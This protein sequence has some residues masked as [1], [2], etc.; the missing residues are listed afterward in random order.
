M[1]VTTWM[2]WEGGVDLV[3]ATRPDLTQPNV[4][5]HIARIVHTPAGSAPSGMVLYQ[6]D[7]GG[8]PQAIGFLSHD[9]GVGAFFGPNIF[10]GTPFESAP[11]LTAKVEV[12]TTD[13]PDAVGARV[14]LLDGI[15][16]ETRLS[17]LGELYTIHRPAEALPFIQ[18]GVEAKAASATLSVNG[19]SVPLYLPPV[20]IS[21][22]PPAVWAPCGVYAR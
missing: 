9:P 16:F 19:E 22:G 10:A 14:T 15:T 6:P 12:F 8:P 1:S 2:S 21:G 17:G 20:G 18:Q 7:P 5:V 3:A 11:V 4:I 13:L